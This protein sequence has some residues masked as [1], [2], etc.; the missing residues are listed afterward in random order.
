MEFLAMCV[1]NDSCVIDIAV[2]F[3]YFNLFILFIYLIYFIY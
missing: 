2:T 1:T 3:S